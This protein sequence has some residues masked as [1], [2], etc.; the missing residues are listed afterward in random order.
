M[1]APLRLPL[2]DAARAELG[3]R[4]E[5]TTDADSPGVLISTEVIVPPYIAP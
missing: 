1:P 2:D 5:A 4:F 3:D